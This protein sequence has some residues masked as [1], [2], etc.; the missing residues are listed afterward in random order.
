VAGVVASP[1]PLWTAEDR[2]GS[3]LAS[4]NA[5]PRRIILDTDPGVDDAMAI[6]LALRSPEWIENV[7]VLFRKQSIGCNRI[8]CLRLNRPKQPL[9]RPKAV[10]GQSFSTLGNLDYSL[11]RSEGSDVG[12]SKPS[13]H[14]EG[15][16]PELVAGDL[17]VTLLDAQPR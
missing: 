3:M 17:V 14:R 6:F 8:G 16:F 5:T 2:G 9:N 11:G 15:Y 1:V 13:L 7:F 12:K 10:V 4:P